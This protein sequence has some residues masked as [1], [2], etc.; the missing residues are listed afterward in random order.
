MPGGVLEKRDEVVTDTR[1]INAYLRQKQLLAARKK[2]DAA[3]SSTT[4]AS[5]VT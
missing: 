4:L 2:P 1:V 3:G 5:S